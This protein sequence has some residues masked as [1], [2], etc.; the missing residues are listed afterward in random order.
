MEKFV[1]TMDS[2]VEYQLEAMRKRKEDEANEV[3]C[4]REAVCG[5][6]ARAV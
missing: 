2:F 3:S 4:T 6:A 1:L 5:T